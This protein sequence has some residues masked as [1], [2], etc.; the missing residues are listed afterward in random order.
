MISGGADATITEIKCIISV[1]HL[2]HS[3]IITPYPPQPWKNCLPHKQFQV[4]ERLGTAVQLN[5][6]GVCVGLEKT[7][8]SLWDSKEI[9][10]VHLKGNQP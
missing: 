8:E 5:D 1:M 6:S 9:K 7:L 3:Q 2:N 4:S 10:S